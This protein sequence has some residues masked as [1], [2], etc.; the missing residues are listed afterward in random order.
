MVRLALAG[1]VA[2][3]L[4]LGCAGSV[5]DRI[6]EV[7]ALQDAGQFNESV[8][9]LRELL[10]KHPDQ[11]EANYLLGVALVQTGQLSLAVWP[12]EKAAADP[13]QGPT[14][15]LLLASTFLGLESPDDAVRVVTKVLES[16]PDRVP[17]L[18]V[19]AQA[20]LAAN[21]REDALKDTAR[22]RELAP[23]D[24]QSLLT[25]GII[26]AELGRLEEA[27]KAHADLE[28]KGA[29]SGDA[30]TA[31]R[32]CL[33][34]ATFYKDNL[35]DDAKAEAHFKKCIEK[36]PT[37]PLALRL[38]TQFYDDRKRSGEA[39]Q[40]WE[41]ALAEAPENLQVRGQLAAR[42]ESQGKADKALALHKEGVELLGSTQAWY[43]LAEFERRSQR[44]DAALEAVDQAI[45]ASPN[46]NENLQF[47]K[48]DL[49]V[50]LDKL[51]EAEALANGLREPSFRD[52]IK[53]R[54]LLTR[55]DAKAA[56]ATFESGLKRWPNNAGGRYLAGLAAHQVGDFPRAESEFR[57]S[58]RVDP[59]ATDA[60]YALASLYLAQGRNKEAV[61]I[62]RAFVGARGGSRPEGYLVYARAA[63]ALGNYESARK[64]IDALEEAGFP[65]EAKAARVSVTLAESGVDAA[66]ELA[67]A[68]GVDWSDR[69]NETLLRDLAE[70][71][72]Q[73]GQTASAEKWIAG[74]VAK[75]PESAPLHDILGS[76]QLRLDQ[77]DAAKASFE[78][79][80]ALDASFT[81]AKAGLASLAL[82]AGDTAAAIAL[83]DEASQGA[84]DSAAAYAAAQ[85]AAQQGDA[86]GARQ[87]L[88]AI[89][90]KDPGH[91][92]ARN[93]LAW[94]LAQEG[95]DL[96]RA[97][98]LA[99][100]AHRIDPGPE[101]ADTLGFVLLQ[102]GQNDRAIELFEKA[103]AEQPGSATIRYHLGLALGKKGEKDRALESLRTALAAGPFPEAEAAKSELARLEAQ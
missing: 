100:A 96:D 38:V 95:R 1:G 30:S 68:Q 14:A 92:G 89:L 8:E 80:L 10:A 97:L 46:P 98:M 20:L 13:T 62:A 90:A 74:L 69:A 58:M 50:D 53:G 63:T 2:C 17:A 51:D 7:R 84:A 3:S 23:D 94:M 42:Y 31:A 34:R 71:S 5:E 15:G 26:L 66:R 86:A 22:L 41:N 28:E 33:A 6:A 29:A 40:I 75:H 57:E 72:I 21:R 44:L 88:E 65:K 47:F 99:E 64:T 73:A 32:A 60:G 48:A 93:D 78:K 16:D 25:H 77:N 9:P 55:G 67:G 18:K 82:R 11:P 59:G 52:L 61:D 43:A 35:K 83:F 36:A 27:D 101:I 19:R 24:Y 54:I 49:L 56:L 91:A 85:L 102:R 103:L 79:A 12:L 76:L 4:A 39:T 87:R 70:A 81:R 37:E 45:A